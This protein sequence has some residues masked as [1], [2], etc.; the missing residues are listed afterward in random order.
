MPLWNVFPEVLKKKSQNQI[1]WNNNKK[2]LKFFADCTLLRKPQWWWMIRQWQVSPHSY[3]KF[4]QLHK[5]V[6]S[7]IWLLAVHSPSAAAVAFFLALVIWLL[8]LT[9]YYK[10]TQNLIAAHKYLQVTQAEKCV[11]ESL[12]LFW[13]LN[14]CLIVKYVGLT[15]IVSEKFVRFPLCFWLLLMC[16]VLLFWV[17]IFFFFPLLPIRCEVYNSSLRQIHINVISDIS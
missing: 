11:K 16:V 5:L 1:K 6:M 4:Y 10:S 2:T 13:Y 8:H 14:C 12:M 3:F 9:Q 17:V 7:S 15:W